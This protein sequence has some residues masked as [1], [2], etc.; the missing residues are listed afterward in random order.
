M[1]VN[2]LIDSS[3]WIEYFAGGKLAEKC[4]RYIE[5]VDKENCF[6]STIILYETYKKLKKEFNE[7]TALSAS[8]L[9]MEHTTL[10]DLDDEIALKAADVSL[11]NK[12]S[13]A[14]SIIMTTAVINNAKIVTM[15]KHFKGLENVVFIG[16]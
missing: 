6:T 11:S 14:D 8:A 3:A 4:S 12:L 1:K 7:E 16:K 10:I 13:M 9:I 15:D 2:V 5:K